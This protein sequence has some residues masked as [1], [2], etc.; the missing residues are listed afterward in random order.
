MCSLTWIHSS[1]S[2]ALGPPFGLWNRTLWSLIRTSK[3]FPVVLCD[4]NSVN[5]AHWKPDLGV[6]FAE[7]SIHPS[8][9]SFDASHENTLKAS[10]PKIA[11]GGSICIDLPTRGTWPEFGE[12]AFTSPGLRLM[13]KTTQKPSGDTLWAYMQEIPWL[14]FCTWQQEVQTKMTCVDI[15]RSISNS[16]LIT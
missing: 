1:V 16:L 5:L 8:E 15:Q 7:L 6:S 14:W 11:A 12:M 3:L 9:Q 13:D 2:V 4:C 10:Q